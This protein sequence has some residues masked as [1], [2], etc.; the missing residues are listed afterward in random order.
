M[1][2]GTEETVYYAVCC[3]FAGA[4]LLVLV[5]LASRDVGAT[6]GEK[7]LVSQTVAITL[8]NVPSAQ[9]RNRKLVL[10]RADAAELLSALAR[11]LGASTQSWQDLRK[12]VDGLPS[13]HV[14]R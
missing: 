12:C 11:E 5:S 7:P 1:K 13:G 14:A 3:A 10:S 6:D 4:A 2:H 8:E 9:V